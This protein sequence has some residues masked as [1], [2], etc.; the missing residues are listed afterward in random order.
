MVR[1]RRRAQKLAAKGLP[2]PRFG[3]KLVPEECTGWIKPRAARRRAGRSSVDGPPRSIRWVEVVFGAS[4][5][6]QRIVGRR[7]DV[8]IRTHRPRMGW[9][10]NRVS[11]QITAAPR[12]PV[13]SRVLMKP[14]DPKGKKKGM[15]VDCDG[16]VIS[17]Q[18]QQQ[19][20]RASCGGACRCSGPAGSRP[21]RRR[22]IC[23]GTPRP[24]SGSPQGVRRP[25]G[26]SPTDVVVGK[27]DLGAPS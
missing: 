25:R 7:A 24:R 17:V 10:G 19:S 20:T 23:D 8:S 1:V 5:P 2:S 11:P 12:F 9:A 4:P 14:T 22:R 21:G 16:V 26:S 27:G 6:R 15:M 3:Y 13:G 18:E